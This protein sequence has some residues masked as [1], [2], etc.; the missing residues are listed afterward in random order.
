MSVYRGV[1]LREV[2]VKR[3]LTVL[4]FAVVLGLLLFHNGQPS[5]CKV[6]LDLAFSR[7]MAPCFIASWNRAPGSV[8][9]LSCKNWNCFWTDWLRWTLENATRQFRWLSKKLE[10]GVGAFVLTNPELRRIFLKD[11]GV[12]ERHVSAVLTPFSVLQTWTGVFRRK[13]DKEA[14]LSSESKLKH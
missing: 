1:R 3:E 5:W 2:T 12:V 13:N 7:F 6:F 10:M 14:Y 4:S 11:S 9:P 8:F